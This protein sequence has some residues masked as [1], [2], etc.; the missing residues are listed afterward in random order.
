MVKVLIYIQMLLFIF[1]Q[2]GRI[3][4][5]GSLRLLFYGIGVYYVLFYYSRKI[6]IAQAQGEVV[7]W[8]CG[9]FKVDCLNDVG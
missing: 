2:Q 5:C 6:F 9:E 7:N 1:Q 3:D 4:I 8:S